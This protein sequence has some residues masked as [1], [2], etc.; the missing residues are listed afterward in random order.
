MAVVERQEL[1]EE[2]RLLLL[3]LLFLKDPV[4]SPF[5]VALERHLGALEVDV[6]QDDPPDEERQYADACLYG[7]GVHQIVRLAPVR[8]GE[9]DPLGPQARMY[10]APDRLQISLDDELAPGR[11]RHGTGDRTAQSVEGERKKESDGDEEDKNR[12]ADPFQS[13]HN[14][15]RSN[16]RAGRG[17]TYREFGDGGLTLSYAL[18]EL[19]LRPRIP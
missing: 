11:L 19:G 8:V 16:A 13:T 18:P 7:V 6:G 12:A 14:L 9:C 10:P 3:L 1:D 2:A 5:G 15:Q 17:E 4:A